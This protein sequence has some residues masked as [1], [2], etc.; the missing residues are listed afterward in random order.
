MHL[1][2]YDGTVLGDKVL[3]ITVNSPMYPEREFHEA[4]EY[5]RSMGVRHIIIPESD[6]DISSFSYNPPNRCYICKKE[7]FNNIIR[8]ANDSGIANVADGSNVD[9]LGDY[10]PGKKALEELG[11]I[12]PLKDA[13]M[14]KQDIRALSRIM[15][16]PTWDKPAFACLASRFPYG[17]TINC[18]KLGM[19]EKA[20]Q[21]LIDIGFRQVRVRHHGNIA[22]IEVPPEDRPKFFDVDLMDRIYAR[23]KEIGFAYTSLDLKGYRT[24]SMNETLKGVKQGTLPHIDR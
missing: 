7:I 8:I 3:A 10:R 5:V 1:A 22:R 20:E 2:E 9:D 17:E 6:I 16:L 4:L 14:G 24:G 21:F 23:F 19:V 11:V 12:S 18:E 15:G 13:G